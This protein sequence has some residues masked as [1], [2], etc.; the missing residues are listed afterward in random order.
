MINKNFETQEEAQNYYLWFMM[1]IMQKGRKYPI[2]EHEEHL[3]KQIWDELDIRDQK[4]FYIF[5][6]DFK[7]IE[8]RERWAT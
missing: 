7:E 3:I 2:E 6:D 1:N 8:K 4:H 5:S